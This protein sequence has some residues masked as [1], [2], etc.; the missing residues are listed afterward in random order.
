MHF[1][2]RRNRIIKISIFIIQDVSHGKYDGQYVNN[3]LLR[4]EWINKRLLDV[5][6][7]K[8]VIHFSLPGFRSY[9]QINKTCCF[10]LFSID[11]MFFPRRILMCVI[12]L[13]L[14]SF[15]HEAYQT[16]NTPTL[17]NFLSGNS[18]VKL[19]PNGLT[20]HTHSK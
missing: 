6:F 20:E 8:I 10:L 15:M 9:Q 4:I 19:F 2:L 17:L 1:C 14:L 18:E 13:K 5:L 12:L 3:L 11:A 16:M 7:N